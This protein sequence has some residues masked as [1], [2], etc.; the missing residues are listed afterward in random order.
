MPELDLENPGLLTASAQN[1]KRYKVLLVGSK[2]GLTAQ[3]L[4]QDPAWSGPDLVASQDASD[5][6]GSATIDLGPLKSQIESKVEQ[7]PELAAFVVGFPGDG[8]DGAKAVAGP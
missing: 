6:G 7:C 4:E 2:A 5:S 8:A 1:A 3:A